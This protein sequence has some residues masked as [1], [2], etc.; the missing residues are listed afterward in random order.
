MVI[1][2][3]GLHKTIGSTVLYAKLTPMGSTGSY[4]YDI[5]D[6]RGYKI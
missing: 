1:N 5:A 2:T 4:A 6:S 3:E